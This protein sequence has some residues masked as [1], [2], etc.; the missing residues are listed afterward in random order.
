MKALFV[1]YGGGHV[2]MCLPVMR[3]LRERLPDCDVRI[4]ALT[5]AYG[6]AQRAAE[7]PLGYRDFDNHPE[8][9]QALR[10][11][12]ML[13]SDDLH[14]EVLREESVAYLGFNILEWVTAYGEESAWARWQQ[15]GR[16]GF[17]PLNFFRF[18]L[19]TLQ[20]DIV[21]T[22]NSPRSEQ[23]AIEA[24]TALGIPSLS[25]V[26]L[27]ALPGDPYLTRAVHAT[28]ITV[29]AAATQANLVAAGVDAQRIVVTGNPAF[30]QAMRPDALSQGHALRQRLGWPETAPVMLW[31]GALEPMDTPAHLAGPALAQ[32]VQ[33]RLLDLLQKYTALHL[34]VRYHP[35]T[36]QHFSRPPVH[37]R[38]YWS[39]PNQEG[40]LPS[41][42]AADVVLVQVS[43]VG[44]QAWS[45]GKEVWCLTSSPLVQRSGM[46]FSR[47]GLA[48]AIP[49]LD[50]LAVATAT[51]L[52]SGA[53][54]SAGN[55]NGPPVL[56]AQSAGAAHAVAEEVI[57]LL[58]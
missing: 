36:W 4:L 45:A 9:A 40:L 13:V 38:I 10:F 58:A 57:A 24:A 54:R 28:R 44:V 26:D 35:N 12:E 17:K 52:E 43:T 29:M 53:T 48:R 15:L 16:H 37:P 31:A 30:D 51:W 1:T 7:S 56:S 39:Q 2:E 20:P 34:I 19:Q 33:A 21:V 42:V 25:M 27:F 41:L 6:V 3:A 50:A 55:A 23:A 32:S 14:P 8:A 22:T 5:T 46:D 11:G 47:L 18:V 49:T